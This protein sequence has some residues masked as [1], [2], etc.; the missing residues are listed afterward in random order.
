[1]ATPQPITRSRSEPQPG[2]SR[3]GTPIPT[4]PDAPTRAY[5]GIDHILGD[6]VINNTPVIIEPAQT[7]FD[8]GDQRR[9]IICTPNTAVTQQFQIYENQVYITTTKITREAPGGHIWRSEFQKIAESQLVDFPRGPAQR[10]L[11][12]TVDPTTDRKAGSSTPVLV[13]PGSGLPVNTRPIC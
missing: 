2:P 1:M 9:T 11:F 8:V 6:P 3:Q 5:Q 10:H 7:F 12:D 13:R 4:V